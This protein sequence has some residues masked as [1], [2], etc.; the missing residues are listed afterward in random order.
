[1]VLCAEVN[2][3]AVRVKRGCE[4]NAVVTWCHDMAKSPDI[5]SVRET[6]GTTLFY[7]IPR[8]VAPELRLL[9]AK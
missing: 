6:H 8:S 7:P 9:C 4:G 1:M 3:S 5:E 2:M